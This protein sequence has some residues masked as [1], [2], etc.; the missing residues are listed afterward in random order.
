M[1]EDTAGTSCDDIVSQGLFVDGD[2]P[3]MGTG[4]CR[5]PMK[6]DVPTSVDFVFIYVENRNKIFTKSIHSNL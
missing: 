6:K 1:I 2:Y 5:W 4:K 3:V